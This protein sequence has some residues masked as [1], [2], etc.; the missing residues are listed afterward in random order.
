MPPSAL[1]ESG[2]VLSFAGPQIRERFEQRCGRLDDL[3]HASHSKKGSH[4][5]ESRGVLYSFK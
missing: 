4:A 3:E 2:G 5:V 1:I